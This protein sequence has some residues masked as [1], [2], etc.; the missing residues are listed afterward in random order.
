MKGRQGQH[1]LDGGAVGVGDDVVLLRQDIGIDLR[2]HK[3]HRRVHA[4]V[5][6]V[7]HHVAA[8]G[9]KFWRQLGRSGTAGGE[10]GKDRLAGNGVIGTHYR[11]LTAFKRDFL[12]PGTLRGYRKK[13]RYR[14]IPFLQDL[15]HL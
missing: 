15:Q 5:G 14:E 11:P 13:L 8:D 3:R 2:H 9:G 10:Y 6:G 7:V 1:H 4:P 12:A